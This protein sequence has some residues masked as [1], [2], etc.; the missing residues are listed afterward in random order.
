MPMA[1][2]L[3][4]GRRVIQC[5][6]RSYLLVAT[7]A[8]ALFF[9]PVPAA[10][11]TPVKNDPRVLRV[12]KL[13]HHEINHPHRDTNGEFRMLTDFARR[14]GMTIMWL[15]AYQPSE[16]HSRLLKGEGD[17]VVADLPPSL[18]VDPHLSASV[19]MGEYRYSVIGRHGIAASHPGELGGY[20]VAVPLASPL[21]PYFNRL[22]SRVPDIS[23]VVLPVDTSRDTILKA[24]SDGDYDIAV[25]PQRP[26]EDPLENLPGLN[27]LFELSDLRS[28][29]WYFRKK[30]GRL[31]DDVNRYLQRFHASFLAPR[32][33]LGDLDDIKRRRVL[34]VITRVDPQNYFLRGGQPVGFEY[35]LVRLFTRERGLS[36]EF[37]V[38]ETDQQILN[39]LRTGAGDVITTRINA[40]DVRIDPAL[41]QSRDYFHSASVIISRRG[42]DISR[43]EHLHGKRVA[44]LGSTVHHRALGELVAAGTAIEPIIISPDTPLDSI[45]DQLE[46]WVIDAAIVDAY[47]VDDIRD[48]HPLIQAGASLPVQ[49]KYAWT[50]RTHDTNLRAAVDDLLR[51]QFRMET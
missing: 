26:D 2:F 19:P 39:W 34:R 5:P 11:K 29:S 4:L 42:N 24:T 3:M 41:E 9:Q 38:G 21:W 25:I 33:V 15:D 13:K 6:R 10:G 1:R 18:I 50:V 30:G 47:A 32:A 35:E 49:F 43:P 31:R 8:I 14:Q 37:L 12:L 46:N 40:R 23:I 20:R 44:V 27:T 17:V 51:D 7:A 28:V 36:V 22:Q 48:G 45:I 16:L